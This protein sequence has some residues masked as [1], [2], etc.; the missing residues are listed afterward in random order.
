MSLEKIRE[1]N[2]L[3]AD[4][5]LRVKEIESEL[6]D[7]D[8]LDSS[9]ALSNPYEVLVELI[10]E[11]AKIEDTSSKKQSIEEVINEHLPEALRLIIAEY[12]AGYHIGYSLQ[13]E[14]LSCI[15]HEK[16]SFYS[17]FYD[18]FQ[19]AGGNVYYL[20][21]LTSYEGT[22]LSFKKLVDHIKLNNKNGRDLFVSEIDDLGEI[23]SDIYDAY[24]DHFDLMRLLL[25]YIEYVDYKYTAPLF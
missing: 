8:S 21:Y 4:L 24:P 7:S 12:V 5:Q 6:V 16:S 23:F 9:E 20:G 25:A 17:K 3:I 11:L 22:I 2:D 15:T 13:N 10:A 14:A 1:I 19:H 18:G